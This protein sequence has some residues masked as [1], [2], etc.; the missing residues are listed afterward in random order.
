MHLGLTP[1]HS[2]RTA[3]SLIEQAVFAEQLGYESFW[4]P[5]NHFQEN[6]IP[7]PL[8]LLASVAG[9]TNTIKLATAS[10]LLPL[11]H[12]LHAAAQVSTLDQ[13]SSGRLILGVGRG[14]GANMLRTFDVE[15][16]E[17]RE[18]F[19]SHLKIMI[20]AWSGVNLAEN[21]NS[22]NAVILHPLPVQQP[23]PPIW[24]AAFGPKALAQ[25]G[26]LGLP[27]LASPIETIGDLEKNFNLHSQACKD[28]EQEIPKIRPIMRTVF[29]S[30]ND[31]TINTLRKQLGENHN[32]S[33]RRDQRA[34]VD[35]WAIIG[36]ETFAKSKLIEYQE[37]LAM[38]HLIVTRMQID[39]LSQQQ[40]RESLG[41]ISQF[42]SGDN[43][44]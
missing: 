41:I 31:A 36:N 35:D 38:T 37:R 40:L 11:R 26:R 8:M 14:V 15:P 18:R 19:E 21:G 25:A 32:V 39:S 12:P 22:D 10:Y 13:L 17:K 42:S 9:A 2:D 28:A 43:A 29:I 6:A 34:L 44:V 1:W 7:D 33:Q 5:E 16:N 3:K 27:Y 30:N 24:V 20:D 4:L 23:H